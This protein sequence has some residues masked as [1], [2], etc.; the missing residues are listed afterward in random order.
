MRY[1]PE[2]LAGLAKRHFDRRVPAAEL[3]TVELRDG[4]GACVIHTVRGGGKIFV[5]PDGTVLF[6][7]SAV[8]LDDGLALFLSGRRTSPERFARPTR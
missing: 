2:E 7:G 4:A 3:R 5:A 1:N 6:V 8:G